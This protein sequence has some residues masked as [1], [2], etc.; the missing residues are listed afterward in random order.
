MHNVERILRNLNDFCQSATQCTHANA[1]R[2]FEKKFS[3]IIFGY[4]ISLQLEDLQ[5]DQ[6]KLVVNRFSAWLLQTKI[7][8]GLL[9]TVES[10]PHYL[11]SWFSHYYGIYPELK[12]E[13]ELWFDEH[14]AALASLDHADEI[15]HGRPLKKKTPFIRRT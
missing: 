4:K 8:Q 3:E 11:S 9:Y 12:N 7:K 6:G 13:K 10:V 14:H 5:G 15:K 2:I 1:L